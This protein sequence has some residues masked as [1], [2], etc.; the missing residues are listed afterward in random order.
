MGIAVYDD[1]LEVTSAGALH[2]GLTPE[3]LFASHES[4]P[5]NPLIA[6]AFYLR[7]LIE[8]W[9]RGI[10][11]IVEQTRLAGLAPPEIEDAA[12]SVTVRFRNSRYVAPGVG[13]A[14]SGERRAA[15]LAMLADRPLAIREISD[16]L[17][18]RASRNTLLRDLAALRDQGLVALT[19]RGR[20]ARWKLE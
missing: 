19:G 12:G 14:D 16:L 1:R 15:I 3:R 9:G 10:A 2:F 4:M 18:G 17:R 5:R 13:S 20:S 6:R 7:G 8:E 11:R